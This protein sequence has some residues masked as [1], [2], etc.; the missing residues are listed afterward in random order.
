MVNSCSRFYTPG[1]LIHIFPE[2]LFSPCVKGVVPTQFLYRYIDTKTSPVNA[3][4][5]LRIE[6]ALEA[7]LF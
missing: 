5:R 4:Y 7:E 3:S 1:S 6:C 2:M